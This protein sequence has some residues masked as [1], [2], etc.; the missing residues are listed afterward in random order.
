MSA[1]TT[2]VN[3]NL[4]LKGYLDANSATGVAPFPTLSNFT[5]SCS[6]TPA[7]QWAQDSGGGLHWCNAGVWQSINTT[8]FAAAYPGGNTCTV[9]TSPNLTWQGVLYLCAGTQGATSNYTA[10]AYTAPSQSA[11]TITGSLVAGPPTQLTV[12]QGQSLLAV[13]RS[14]AIA[15]WGDS[16]TQ[17]GQDN[18]GDNYP[19]YLQTDL[20][21]AT[22]NLGISGQ[23]S[24][25]IAAR[26]T[27]YPAVY[28]DYSVI[29]SGRNDAGASISNS[30]TL[31][32]IAGMASSLSRYV[33]MSIINSQLEPSGSSPYTNIVGLNS[34][35]SSAYSTGNHYLDIRAALVADYNSGNGADVANHAADLVPLSLRAVTSTG[36]LSGAISSTS[37][38]SFTLSGYPVNS[39]DTILVDS[40]YIVLIAFSGQTVSQCTRGWGSTAAT[41]LNGASYTTYDFLHLGAAGYQFVATTLAAFINA[42]DA[43]AGGTSTLLPIDASQQVALGAGALSANTTGTGNIAI[44]QQSMLYNTSGSQNTAAGYWA[45]KANTTAS[46]NTAF[47]WFDLGSTTTGGQNVAFGAAA[48][49]NNTTGSLNVGIGYQAINQ[50]QTGTEM[51]A[52]GDYALQNAT[53]GPNEAFG[54]GA[55]QVTTTGTDNDAFG[56]SALAFN[57][58]GSGNDAFGF[59]S[60]L[61]NTTG[62]SNLG[63]GASTLYNNT[64]GSA[65]VAVGVAALNANT[66]ASDNVA[67]GYKAMQTA[68][69]SSYN[70]AVGWEA[71]SLMTAG[72]NEALG[73]QALYTN[74]TG[75]NNDAFGY[76]SLFSNTTGQYNVAFGQA[77]IYSNATGSNL[78][79]FGYQALNAATAGPNDAFGYQSQLLTTTGASNSAFGYE[80]LSHNTT[81]SNNAADGELSLISNTTGAFNSC[82]GFGSCYGNT[83]ASANTGVGRG[84]LTGTTTGSYNTGLGAESGVTATSTNQNTTGTYNTYLGAYSGP[85]S[86]TQQTYQTVIGAYATAACSSCVVIGRIADIM[87]IQP[88][89]YSALPACASGVQGAVKPTTDG[90]TNT[91]G[92]TVAS[93]GGTV[94][95]LLYCD[96]TNWTVIGK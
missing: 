60:L 55:L 10:V 68:Q 31:S 94:P 37:T 1:Q 13:N 77:A 67:I 48:L 28:P 93:G 54:Y 62:F 76:Q 4:Q 96:G 40:E 12:S 72:P 2:P 71:L 78:S 15:G 42:H 88:T 6:T 47:G 64:T 50:N 36:T 34:S 41:H 91:W 61:S 7:N 21:R 73:Y 46:G 29:W 45:L 9:G 3:T 81:G 57:T 63:M 19:G 51:T 95:A 27:A 66:T 49:R 86:T 70:T 89:T 44:G 52:L 56:T 8:S 80:S 85:S 16:L 90:N 39:G 53:A 5:G 87:L 58:T 38:C 22:I 18:A 92:A 35:L 84:A 59:T 75:T 33:V 83:T 43:V 25:Q 23:T 82:F 24:T 17:G 79:A 30:T 69:T 32:N 11:N 20:G 74:S 14:T 65:N 26:F